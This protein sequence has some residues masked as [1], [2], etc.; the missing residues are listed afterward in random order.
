MNRYGI[1]KT[2]TKEYDSAKIYLNRSLKV[3][4]EIEDLDG[5]ARNYINLAD[6]AILLNRLDEAENLLQDALLNAKK[7]QS[8]KWLKEVYDRL[9]QLARKQGDLEDAILYYDQYVKQKDS[10]FNEQTLRNIARLEAELATA[11]QRRQLSAQEQK[12]LILEQDSKI[13]QI[14]LVVF[15]ILGISFFIVMILY[16]RNRRMKL[17]RRE[18]EAKRQSESIKRE[19]DFKNRELVSYTVNFVQKNQLFEDLNTSIAE[20][21]KTSSDTDRKTL[22]GMERIIKKHLQIDRDW[23]DF[24]V[25]FENLH[26]GFFDHLLKDNP[27]LTSNDLRLCALTKMNFSIKEISDMMGISAESVKTARYR[28]KKKLSLPSDSTINDYLNKIDD[29]YAH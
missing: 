17:E 5:I 18:Q 14:Q 21:K 24:K 1:L 27:A 15:I 13:Q 12:I 2:Q 28:L 3:S 26:S 6:L 8:N 19:L 4:L 10:I 11:E 7:V 20:I 16:S 22:I 9:Q 29:S 23:E 25:R